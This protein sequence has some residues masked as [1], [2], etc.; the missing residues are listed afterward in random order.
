MALTSAPTPWD[1]GVHHCV[2]NC[3]ASRHGQLS[4]SCTH[5]SWPEALLGCVMG[6]NLPKGVWEN[7]QPRGRDQRPW[8]LL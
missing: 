6:V 7:A 2:V 5:P 3:V 1:T 4:P 8:D